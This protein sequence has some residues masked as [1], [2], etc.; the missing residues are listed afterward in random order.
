MLPLHKNILNCFLQ[1]KNER[2]GGM[3]DFNCL[4]SFEIFNVS[5]I[6]FKSLYFNTL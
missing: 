2:P 4:T 1:L 6:Y 5:F 3:K